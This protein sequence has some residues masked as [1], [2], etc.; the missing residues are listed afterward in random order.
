MILDFYSTEHKA[1]IKKLE[2]LWDNLH[3]L[4]EL[5]KQY[6]IDDIFQDNG[7]K[8]L[9][10]LIYLNMDLLPG[11]EGNDCVSKSGVEWEM[12]SINLDTSASGFSTNHHTN[13]V[14]IE[15]YRK[16]PWTFAIYNGI[17]LKEIYIMTP[18]MLEPIYL[19]WE[20]KLKTMQHLN[21]PKIPVKF[22]RK[23]GIMVYPIDEYRPLDPDSINTRF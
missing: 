9:Q 19:H 22:V 23:N 10:Q 18:E 17:T 16:I 1:Q 13:H 6:G 14:I 15:K 8:V 3:V 21:N 11:R 5:A 12:K 2:T 4:S 20:K 7:A